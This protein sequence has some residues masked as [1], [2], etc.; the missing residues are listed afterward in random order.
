MKLF[1]KVQKGSSSLFNKN[2]EPHQAFGKYRQRVKQHE[3]NIGKAGHFI[4]NKRNDLEIGIR[5]ELDR[6]PTYK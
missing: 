2:T 5:K 4:A 6:G 1:S 3:Q